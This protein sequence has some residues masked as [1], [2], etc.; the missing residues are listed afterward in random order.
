MKCPRC[1]N[2]HLQKKGMRAGKQRY[3]CMN[4]FANFCEGIKY[5]SAPKLEK[6]NKTCLYCG[7]THIS[8]DGWVSMSLCFPVPTPGGQAGATLSTESLVR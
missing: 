6:L 1:G 4:C 8:R 2:E 7:G 3:K 5:I